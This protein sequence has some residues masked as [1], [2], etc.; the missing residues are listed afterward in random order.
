MLSTTFT[1]LHVRG[2]FESLTYIACNHSRSSL[3]NYDEYP[4]H[5]NII[6]CYTGKGVLHVL[7]VMTGNTRWR[8]ETNGS[9]I[10]SSPAISDDGTIYFESWNQI[11]YA[12]DVS[13]NAK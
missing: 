4:S 12:V 9:P 8:F 6:D 11:Y 5:T 7:D 13:G 10:V 3:K 2:V 1:L